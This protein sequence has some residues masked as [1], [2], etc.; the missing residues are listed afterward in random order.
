MI[1]SLYY[2]NVVT[3]TGPVLFAAVG[4]SITEAKQTLIDFGTDIVYISGPYKLSKD[5]QTD[6]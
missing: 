4:K 5:W 6:V 2:F 3:K 1:K